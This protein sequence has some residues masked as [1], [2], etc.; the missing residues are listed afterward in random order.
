MKDYVVVCITTTCNSEVMLLTTKH[1]ALILQMDIFLVTRWRD[2]YRSAVLHLDYVESTPQYLGQV[3][4]EYISGI[5]NW[6]RLLEHLLLKLKHFWP[7]KPRNGYV[8]NNTWKNETKMFVLNFPQ[9]SCWNIWS[10]G[11]WGCSNCWR[12]GT[13]AV[14]RAGVLW[15]YE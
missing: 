9:G 5:I 15:V 1:V 12:F 4:F 3:H 2:H 14:F 6:V 13:T 7:K 11:R 8:N 10:C